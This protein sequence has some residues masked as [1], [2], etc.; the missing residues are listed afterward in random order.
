VN[1]LDYQGTPTDDQEQVTQNYRGQGGI[2]IGG[3]FQR[4]LFAWRYRDVNLLISGLI[5]GDSRIMIYRDIHTRAPKAAPFL[6]FD[7][8]P[9]AAVV[10]GRLV[11]IW[12]AYTTTNEYP[13]S[14]P[15]SLDDVATQPEI[16]DEF[17][18]LTG[19]ANYIRNSVKVVVDAYDG[20][21][22][23]YLWDESDP[24]IRVWRN[25]F[26]DLFTPLSEATPDL[27]AHFRYPENL[28]QVQA[29]QFTQYH[30]TS[31]DVF[32]GRQ[33]FWE[34]PGDP[35][36]APPVAPGEEPTTTTPDPMRP[37]YVLMRLPGESERTFTLILPFTP[38]GRQ[39]MVAWLAA[40]SDPADGYGEI[41]SYEF[42]SGRNVD[43]P[44]QV[45]AR[46]NADSQFASE[47]TLL[48]QAGS[49][50]L[51]GDLLVVPIDDSLL[52]V[53]PVYVE[54]TQQNAIPEL[55]RVIVVNGSAIGIGS[56][57]E[58]ALADALGDVVTPPPPPD[59]DGDEE[60]PPTGTIDEQIQAL[61]EEAA[62]HFALADAALRDGDLATYQ[63]EVELAQAAIEE[64]QA[65]AGGEAEA[66]P[67]PSP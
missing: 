8:D 61:L 41:I 14:Q 20:T 12:D 17:P 23:Y 30:V 53:L 29:Q 4:A 38:A 57:L 18:S 32:Y 21:T 16:G 9:Y 5:K 39:N 31:P 3:P 33:D 2:P 27:L 55:R 47:R 60:P 49:Q 10:D 22:K 65:L 67:S 24:I 7:W 40:K 48:G 52:Y 42:P 19:E 50:V 58:E 15:V 13:Y 11:W 51:F 6:R 59:G 35:A 45:F 36:S 66:S 44:T 1:E 34:F 62:N 28:F 46:V 64:A 54:S 37:Y 25:A 63:R 43:G 56:T 26:P